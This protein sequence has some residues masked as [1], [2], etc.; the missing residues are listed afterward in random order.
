MFMPK[1]EE[2]DAVRSSINEHIKETIHSPTPKKKKKR[3]IKVP[4]R[5]FKIDLGWGKS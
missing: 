3:K 2:G 4:T 5:L 1:Q